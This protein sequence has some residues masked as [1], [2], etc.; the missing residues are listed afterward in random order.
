MTTG[1]IPAR[2]EVWMTAKS[3][4]PPAGNRMLCL[5]QRGVQYRHEY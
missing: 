1:P 4:T 5:G 3:P 2:G